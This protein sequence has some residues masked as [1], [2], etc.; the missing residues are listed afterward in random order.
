M[1][2]PISFH[3]NGISIDEYSAESQVVPEVV[4]DIC[5]QAAA[6]PDYLLTVADILAWEAEFG[7]ISA[8]NVVLL[9]ACGLVN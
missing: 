7:T 1:N 9:Y 3:S 4:I 8:E 6:N 5:K 2:A